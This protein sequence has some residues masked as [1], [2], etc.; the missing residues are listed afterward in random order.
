MQILPRSILKAGEP[1]DPW[2]KFLEL[3]PYAMDLARGNRKLAVHHSGFR[4]GAVALAMSHAGDIAIFSGANQNLFP[5]SNPTKACAEQIVLQKMLYHRFGRLIAMFS[6]GPVQ[7]D[8][9]S[10]IDVPTLHACGECR[11]VMEQQPAVKDDSL[12]VT[13]HPSEDLYEIYTFAELKDI[14]AQ[15]GHLPLSFSHHTDPD[16]ERWARS[17]SVYGFFTSL[18][19]RGRELNGPIAARLAIAVGDKLLS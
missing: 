16:F 10:G 9:Q 18:H 5:G 8:T 1:I 6:S 3:G 11:D 7:P 15:D 4:V 12:M 17:V 2:R 19:E 14:H 13:V